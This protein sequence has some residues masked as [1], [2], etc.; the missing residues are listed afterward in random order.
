MIGGSI[1][2]LFLS[3]SFANLFYTLSHGELRVSHRV[4]QRAT[5]LFFYCLPLCETLFYS[6]Q[7]CEEKVNLCIIE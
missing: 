7:L 1:I 2:I 6:V 3:I 4:S 5:P